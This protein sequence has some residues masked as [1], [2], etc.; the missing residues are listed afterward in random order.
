MI[1]GLAE[2]FNGVCPGVR[3]DADVTAARAYGCC[4]T[5]V[6]VCVREQAA[7]EPTSAKPQAE[8]LSSR[9]PNDLIAWAGE[10]ARRMYHEDDDDDGGAA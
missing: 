4:G 2:W 1:A 8:G 5:H 7:A 3:V 10:T 6:L 9:D